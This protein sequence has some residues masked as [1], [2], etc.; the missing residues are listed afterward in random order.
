MS[1]S[2]TLRRAPRSPAARSTGEVQA[3]WL[4]D[5][6]LKSHKSFLAVPVHEPGALLFIDSPFLLFRQFLIVG[7]LAGAFC[8]ARALKFSLHFWRLPAGPMKP[9]TPRI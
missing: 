3:R 4:G 2:Q 7:G 9:D 1:P 5:Q 8:L 6:L